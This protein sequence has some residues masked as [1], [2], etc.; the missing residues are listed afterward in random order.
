MDHTGAVPCLTQESFDGNGVAP[1]PLAQYLERYRASLSML[2]A[3]HLRRPSFANAL[4]E[5]VAG[6]RSTG[7]VLVS[8]GGLSRN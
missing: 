4:E 1:E 2:G 7:Q 6:D 5:A 8:H 3:V